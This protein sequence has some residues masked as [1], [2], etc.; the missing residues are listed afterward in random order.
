MVGADR[1]R[2][3]RRLA[4]PGPGDH[5]GDRY[6]EPGCERLEQVDPDQFVVER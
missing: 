2:Q 3:R 1:L 6:V 5:R 4:E